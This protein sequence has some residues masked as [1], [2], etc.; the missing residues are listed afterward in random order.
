MKS[1]LFLALFLTVLADCSVWAKTA[2][3]V[4]ESVS[5]SIVIVLGMDAKGKVIGLGS[6][7]VIGNEEI[8][9]NCHVIEKA[10]ALAI[11]HSERKLSAKLKHADWTRDVCS[12][13]VNG[14]NVP[15]AIL[16]STIKLKVGRKVFAIGAPRGLELTLSEGIVSSLREMGDGHYLQITAPISPG[17]SGGGLF[18]EEGRLIGLPTFYL[19]SGQQLNFAIPVE[20]IKSLAQR[21]TQVK[22]AGRSLSEW[23]SK[24]IDL[25]SR[26]DFSKLLEHARAWTEA[27]PG[28][29]SAWYA[30]GNAYGRTAQYEK[31]IEA[32]LQ[33][34][35]IEPKSGAVWSNLGVTLSR[36]GQISLS[37]EAYQQALDIDPKN[38]KDWLALGN[39]YYKTAQ[40]EKAGEAYQQSLRIDPQ[41]A[42]AWYGLG[43]AYH[44][45]SQFKKAI[46]A[47]QQALRINP[48]YKE[49]WNNL[50]L[51][52]FENGDMPKS[53][54]A[55][56]QALHID[57]RYANA[58]YGLGL[59]YRE[60]GQRSQVNEIYQRLKF[61]DSKLAEEFFRNVVL[62]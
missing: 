39:A 25:E 27:Q 7:V 11:K 34:L 2:T 31:A 42:Q 61:L 33:S 1:R 38:V 43:S 44:F 37:I 8:V 5:P 16:G 55:F 48:K 52:Y 59:I 57:P 60:A 23:V 41:E 13:T 28:E 53:I 30:L 51:S 17:S 3:E 22:K 36:T 9:T 14:L 12:L 21:S 29:P 15:S 19:S 49:A 62:P 58:L 45:T 6:G 20:W 35:H 47:Y 40:Y 56:E 32:Y 46:E 24:T 26:K 10:A 4:F 54:E 50:G 18:D